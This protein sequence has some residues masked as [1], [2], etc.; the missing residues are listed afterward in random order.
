MLFYLWDGA[1][2]G[3]RVFNQPIVRSIYRERERELFYLTT[4]STH[5]IYG[6]IASDIWL[7]TILI[8]RKETRC[9]QRGYSYRLTARVLLYATSHRQDNT[10][11]GLCYTSRGALAG[12]SIEI[13]VS[14]WKSLIH[15]HTHSFLP[16]FRRLL[17]RS[18]SHSVG[19]S[20]IYVVSQS[21]NRP[22]RHSVDQSLVFQSV[23]QFTHLYVSQSVIHSINQLIFQCIRHL[24]HLHISQ[25]VIH[26]IN[27]FVFQ[28]IRQFT[29]LHISQSVIHSINQFVF[30]CIRQFT[31]LHVSQVSD[32]LNQS[33][34]FSLYPSVHPSIRQSASDSLNQSVCL[35]VCQSVHRPT[36]QP[37]GGGGSTSDLTT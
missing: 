15:S 7:R 12:L 22:V 5:F 31:H 25:S 2:Q 32:S 17:I 21:V 37:W 13:L 26:S 30:Q 3:S 11:H 23:R 36:R 6:Y 4:H 28:C 1:C 14:G 29:H 19:L 9:R 16:P 24:T 27:Q 35:S 33:V 34:C 20:F 10:Y 8:V 18:F